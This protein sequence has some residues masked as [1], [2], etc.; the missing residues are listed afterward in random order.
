[1]YPLEST[2]VIR[3]M[4]RGVAG[5]HFQNQDV[6]LISILGLSSLNIIYFG[7]FLP[8][9]IHPH[10]GVGVISLPSRGGIHGVFGTAGVV[11]TTGDVPAGCT[12]AGVQIQSSPMN[13]WDSLP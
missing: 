6:Y 4:P 9:S 7:T 12:P 5:D 3:F 8:P 2:L 10:P 13:P 11:P 1:M